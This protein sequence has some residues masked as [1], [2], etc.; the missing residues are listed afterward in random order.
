MLQE[1]ASLVP[2]LL[3]EAPQE[4]QWR[5]LCEVK[6]TDLLLDLCAAPGSKTLECLEIMQENGDQ[7][8]FHCFKG[9]VLIAFLH[10]FLV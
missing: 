6:P 3:L 4:M 9:R 1:A 5:C 8:A 7:A 2:P 10:L